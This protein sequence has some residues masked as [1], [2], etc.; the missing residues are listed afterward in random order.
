[1]TKS[2][3]WKLVVMFVLLVVSVI[4][5][6]GTFMLYS[7]ATFYHKDFIKQVDKVFAQEDFTSTA[8]DPSE[9]SSKLKTFSVQLG[10]DS[11]RNFYI[12]NKVGQVLDSSGQVGTN[13]EFTE[14]LIN[15]MNGRQG[16]KYN[17]Y[18]DFVDY[19]VPVFFEGSNSETE[20]VIYIKDTKQELREMTSEINNIIFQ[21]L[22]FGL[23]ISIILGF[24]LANTITAPISLLTQK[25]EKMA[26]GD[27]EHIIEVKSDD[28]IGKLTNAF[29]HMAEELKLKL[30]EVAGEKN[31]IEAIFRH[32]TDGVMAFNHEGEI[33][34]INPAAKKMLG[35]RQEGKIIF[36]EY[37]SKNSI[38][39]CLRQVLKLRKNE[40]IEKDID[41]NELYLKGNFAV[42]NVEK[43][44]TGGIVVVLQDVTKQQK[45][46][47]V[48]R[49]F[50]ANVSHELRTP[51][52]SIK[53]YAETL[54]DGAVDDRETASQFLQVINNESDRMTRLVRDLLVLSKLDYKQTSWKK[55][56]FSVK[57]LIDEVVG[58]LSITAKN[59][60]QALTFEA[61]ENLPY[62]YADRDKIEQVITNI[63]AN[64]IKYT[65]IGGKILVSS[66]YNKDIVYITISD[67]G[68]GIP[69]EDL[70]RIFE[71]FYRVDKARSRELGGTGLGLA[72]AK[73]IMKEHNGDITIQSELGSGTKV[74]LNLPVKDTRKESKLKI[75]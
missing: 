28:E 62:I 49:E 44:K 43:A 34:H 26:G 69:K 36:D 21:A 24:L 4:I 66:E 14:N 67:N 47:M 39:I 73:E 63:V 46:E 1:M 30:E 12:L 53:S 58:K 68:M 35:I 71:R 18:Y 75:M 50:V 60:Q 31:K 11:Y 5:V 55:T 10:I 22:L 27:F 8:V 54:L 64:A 20:Y 37:F 61:Q 29:N 70:P 33:I 25:A 9:L 23:A 32:M 40:S 38:D 72:I 42:F 3:Q 57:E 15:A 59:R 65:Q 51:L 19:A 17:L 41:I 7:V 6:I 74:T 56:S 2:I 45:L 48:R 16:A 13:I 52:T